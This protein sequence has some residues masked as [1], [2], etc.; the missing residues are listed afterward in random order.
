MTV[1]VTLICLGYVSVLVLLPKLLAGA[2]GNT[3]WHL[4]GERKALRLGGALGSIRRLSRP[5]LSSWSSECSRSCRATASSTRRP[6]GRCG[7]FGAAWAALKGPIL[8]E[9]WRR[10]WV[11]WK[12]W[13]RPFHSIPECFMNF[14]CLRAC[15]AG[16]IRSSETLVIL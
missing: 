6:N 7:R 13:R 9:S 5:A 12:R 10:S 11:V 1:I 3:A 8:G 2:L 15:L 4:L 14:I 16:V